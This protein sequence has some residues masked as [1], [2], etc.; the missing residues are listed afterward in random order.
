MDR[1]EET[2]DDEMNHD[3]L[4]KPSYPADDARG[5]A[6]YSRDEEMAIGCLTAARGYLDSQGFGAHY[7][8]EEEASGGGT[9]HANEGIQDKSGSVSR[10]PLRFD[11]QYI[12]DA[13]AEHLRLV[14]SFIDD[15][16]ETADVP[17]LPR[18][19]MILDYL[20]YLQRMI[21]T[22]DEQ[23]VA[24]RDARLAGI[25]DLPN[26]RRGPLRQSFRLATRGQH[27][28]ERFDRY[29]SLGADGLHAARRSRLVV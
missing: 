12:F 21:W 2:P 6:F 22:D 23:E 13:R 27:A 16:L 10:R 11:S 3:Y 17:L 28:I 29:I 4:I 24:F 26:G 1:Y 7:R 9:C 5:L 20:P 18:P 15:A 8:R 25:T 19:G 14:V